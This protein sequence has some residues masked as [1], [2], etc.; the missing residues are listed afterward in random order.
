[1]HPMQPAAVAAK[2]AEMAERAAVGAVHDPDHVVHDVGDI[3]E[4]LIRRERHA[5]GRSTV[6]R[7]GRNGEL[8]HELAVLLINLDTVGLAVGSI[9]HDIV[10][11]RDSAW[12][13]ELLWW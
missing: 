13:D 1:M 3:D 9:N 12:A 5:A 6:E 7:F 10:C 2:E 8:A 11:D 4:S